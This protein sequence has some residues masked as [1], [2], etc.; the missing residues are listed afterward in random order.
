ML[1]EDHFIPHLEPLK[2]VFNFSIESQILYHAPLAFE[3]MFGRVPKTGLEERIAPLIEAAADGERGAEEVVKATLEAER[4][5]AW[6]IDD[7]A[8]KVF[9]NSER[10][11]LGACHAVLAFR[12]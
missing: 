2:A 7:E 11:S 8:M 4:E 12:G 9:V 1:T 6:L 10:W 5:E 3:P